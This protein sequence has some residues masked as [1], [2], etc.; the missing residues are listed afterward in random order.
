VLSRLSS[1][2]LTEQGWQTLFPVYTGNA[3]PQYGDRPS[4]LGAYTIDMDLIRCKPRF[5]LVKGFAYTAEFDLDI[6]F[7]LIEMTPT[8]THGNPVA[9]FA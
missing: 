8:A 6:L 5:P 9:T 3:I 1:R 4:L 7:A 2:A